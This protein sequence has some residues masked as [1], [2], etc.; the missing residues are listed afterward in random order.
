MA[1][2]YWVS[3]GGKSDSA[4]EWQEYWYQNSSDI[5]VFIADTVN[6][7]LGKKKKKKLLSVQY[8]VHK[9]KYVTFQLLKMD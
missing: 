2:R 1:N 3:S 8:T 9:L 5:F 6:D 4:T 7:I